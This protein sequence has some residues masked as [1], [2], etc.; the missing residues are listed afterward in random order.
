MKQPS[1]SN[2]TEKS[3]LPHVN[4]TL[5]GSL[6]DRETSFYKYGQKE[7]NYE[8]PPDAKNLVIIQDMTGARS[9]RK[10]I[11]QC[12]QCKTYY[13]FWTDYEYM[14]CGTED[15]EFL[16]RLRPEEVEDYLV[17]PV[18]TNQAK[19]AQTKPPSPL[20]KQPSPS[21]ASPQV[22]LSNAQVQTL[23][24]V[25]V[26]FIGARDQ[27]GYEK[28]W[29]TDIAIPMAAIKKSQKEMLD[30]WTPLFE[31]LKKL[32]I[33]F[34]PFSEIRLPRRFTGGRQR[35]ERL[36]KWLAKDQHLLD[37]TTL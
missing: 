34:T 10:Q 12:P 1:S 3:V 18:N 24:E 14:T 35:F 19:Q 22:T 26:P 21:V 28:A 29:S 9:R 7:G 25:F 36:I 5:C 32:K 20:E 17:N 15:E 30:A 6:G 31:N 27:Y 4:C 16:I 33:A 13:R 23:W 8:L 37:P 2:D 11:K